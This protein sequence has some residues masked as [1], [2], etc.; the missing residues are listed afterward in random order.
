MVTGTFPAARIAGLWHRARLAGR[1][2][3]VTRLR[4]RTGPRPASPAA[5]RPVI[6]PASLDDL[7]GPGSGVVE[8]PVHLYWSG[9]RQ[10]DLADPHQAAALCDAVV[11]AAATTEVLARYLNADVLIRAWPVLGMSRVKRE[12]WERQFPVLRTRRLAAAA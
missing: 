10:F 3:L 12:A 11:D 5:L 7:H 2:R 6:V 1:A 9:S 4:G 8:L